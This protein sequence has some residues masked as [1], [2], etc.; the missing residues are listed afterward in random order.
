MRSQ[1]WGL[2]L[3]RLASFF[4]NWSIGDLYC[5]TS[6]SHC[7]AKDTYPFQVFPLQVTI[8]H[9]W[10]WVWVNSGSWW[11]TGRPG[12]LQ[13][14]GSQRV[15][16]DWVTELNSTGKTWDISN[17]TLGGLL[18][19]LVAQSCLTLCNPMSCSPPGSSIHGV[20]QARIL[21]WIAI[22]FSRR[23]SQPR[24]WTWVSCIGGRFFTIWATRGGC[25]IVGPC[26]LFTF[27]ISQFSSVAQLCPTLCDPMDC[28]TP[29]LPVHHQLPEFTQAHVHWVADAIQPSHPLSSPSPPAFNIFSI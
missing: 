4:F 20:L 21:E 25:Y 15:G 5:C 19:V 6:F 27:Y 3:L 13:F 7:R 16:H 9:Q 22:P 8:R 28:S 29:G 2:D 17:S 24:D 11:W 1:R 26:Y 12:V 10:T 23:S 18:F 14:M